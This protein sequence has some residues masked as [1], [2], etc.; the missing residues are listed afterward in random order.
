MKSRDSISSN[1]AIVVTGCDSGLGYSL[2]LHCRELGAIVIAGV[3]RNDGP[4][5]KKL[6]EQDVF[7]LPL[8]VTKT[9]SVVD[10]VDSVRSILTQKN[11]G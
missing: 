11:L 1:Q 9:N 5:V 7:V 3:L 10:F 4:A 6:K 8:D 2:A